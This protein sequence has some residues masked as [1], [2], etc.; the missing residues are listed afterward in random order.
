MPES[1]QSAMLHYISQT[2]NIKDDDQI[3]TVLSIPRGRSTVHTSISPSYDLFSSVRFSTPIAN[4][5]Y[6]SNS[7]SLFFSRSLGLLHHV[8]P[9][10]AP[11]WVQ[12]S[13]GWWCMDEV[14]CLGGWPGRSYINQVWKVLMVCTKVRRQF[15]LMHRFIWQIRDWWKKQDFN[16]DM[17]FFL[18]HF[19]CLNF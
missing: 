2:L 10:Y 18:S 7:L 16:A 19:R 9:L 13:G 6:M 12:H 1:S 3:L 4:S 14:G 8:L 5:H 11:I 17:I 15:S